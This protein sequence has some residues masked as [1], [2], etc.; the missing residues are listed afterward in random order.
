[1]TTTPQRGSAS[2]AAP[3]VVHLGLVRPP[4]VYLISLVSGTVIHLAVPLPFHRVSLAVA[5][6]ED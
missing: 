1:M 3:D 4:L 5:L 6:G 2:S